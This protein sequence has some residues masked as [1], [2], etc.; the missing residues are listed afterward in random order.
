MLTLPGKWQIWLRIGV[1][2]IVGKGEKG[3]VGVGV[4]S[5]VTMWNFVLCLLLD[6]VV[7]WH[8]ILLMTDVDITFI[9]GGCISNTGVGEIILFEKFANSVWVDVVDDLGLE[10]GVNENLDADGGNDDGNNNDDGD[11]VDDG[12]DFNDGDSNNDELGGFFDSFGKDLTT[13]FEYEG[14]GGRICNWQWFKGVLIV[15]KKLSY[16]EEPTGQW[17]EIMF[18]RFE[19]CNNGVL[20]DN[21]FNGFDF[22]MVNGISSDRG[23][24]VDVVAVSDGNVGNF[25]VRNLANFSLPLS[26][27]CKLS[28]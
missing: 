22:T 19:V 15:G 4:A 1:V 16:N 3:S 12:G 2:G 10:L 23:V 13:E 26:T 21:W 5:S 25:D 14:W 8:L 24:D 17:N 11:D 28:V 18:V 27:R 6:D 20:D 9:T 7:F